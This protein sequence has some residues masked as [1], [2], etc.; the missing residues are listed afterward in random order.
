M[1]KKQ[2]GAEPLGGW[3]LR[4]VQ[5]LIIGVGGILP[6]VSGGVLCVVFGLYRSVMEVCAAPFKN[7]KKYLGLLLPVALGAAVGCFGLAHLVGAAMQAYPDYATAAFVGLILGTLPALLRTARE[8]PAS[9][10]SAPAFF[11]SFVLFFA[12][13]L[14]LGRGEGLAI[15]PNFFW[16]LLT[17]VIWGVS[18]VLPGLSL[19]SILIFLGLFAPLVE[20]AKNLDFAVLLPVGIGGIGAIMLLARLMNR[21][22]A[23]YPAVMSYIILGVV[24]ATTIPLIPTGFASVADFFVR[25]LLL[26]VGF[27]VALAFDRLGTKLGC[28]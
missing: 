15:Q 19:S 22:F 20:G 27:A 26:I 8:K 5:G 9:R 16:Y 25:L 21:L 28:E 11:T 23:R 18:I 12:L 3:I 1:K 10:G 2:I 7:L 4:F 14:L 17:G 6:G 13:F 24:A